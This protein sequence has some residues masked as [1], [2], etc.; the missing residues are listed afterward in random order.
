MDTIAWFPT[1][2]E[3]SSRDHRA[4]KRSHKKPNVVLLI[5]NPFLLLGVLQL[6][7]IEGIGG[8]CGQKHK[9]KEDKQQKGT[10][11]IV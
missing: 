9:S 8:N 1:P 6:I 2:R 7:D 10:H 4:A 3:R 11:Y 5:R